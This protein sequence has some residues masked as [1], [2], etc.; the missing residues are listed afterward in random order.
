MNAEDAL[1]LERATHTIVQQVDAMKQMVNAFSEYAR[2]P[3]MRLAAFQ[4]EPAGDRGRRALPAAGPGGRDSAR[5]GCA[6]ARARGRSWACAPDSGQPDHQRHRG[7][8]RGGAR[9]RADRHAAAATARRR[10]CSHHQCARQWAGVSQGDPRAP[11]RSLRDRQAARHGAG[12]GH[13]QA[14]SRRTRRTHRGGE[15]SPTGGARV[16]VWLPV[17]AQDRALLAGAE[18]RLE[19]RRERA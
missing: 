2:A 18:R 19:L 1:L 3:D 10:G 7:A 16:R 13:R 15:S 8:G 11:V 9:P 17:G 6:A 14:Y 12:T 4:S 5:P